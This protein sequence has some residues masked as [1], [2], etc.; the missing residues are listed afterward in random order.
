MTQ[1]NLLLYLMDTA[2]EQQLTNSEATRLFNVTQLSA[3]ASW[4]DYLLESKVDVAII[5]ADNL[6]HE[7][8]IALTSNKVMSKV[9]VIFISHGEPNDYIDEAMHHGVTYHLRLPV[10]IGFIN[11]LLTDFHQ[12]ILSSKNLS[13]EVT[14]SEL[15][16]FG[17]LVGSSQPMRT[18]Y[19][20][21]KKAADAEMN[22]FVVGESG[23]GKELV[24]RSVHLL[25]PLSQKPFV[26]I[27]CGAL[28]PELIESELFG[29]TKGAFTGAN[30]P[31]AGVFEQAEGGTLF[32]DE[33][34]EMPLDQ[35][36]KLLRVL[37]SGEYRPVGSEQIKKANVRI[38]SATNRD[39]QDAIK[40]ALFRED[41]FFRLAHFPLNV[42]P[43]R[44]RDD[45]IVGLAKH[46]LAYRNAQDKSNKEISSDALQKISQH[47]WPGNVRELKHAIER[48]YILANDVITADLIILDNDTQLRTERHETVPAGISL[49]EVERRAIL[50]TLDKNEGNKSATAD[51]LGVSIKTLYNKL[52]RYS[53]QD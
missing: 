21:I 11:E 33:V 36:V 45:D 48:A 25:S 51:D 38:I 47:S 26:A 6:T 34:T 50:K 53:K 19:R 35:Q 30:K 9:D 22:V 2:L 3:Q 32:L 44:E 5:Q 24:A 1:P 23:A 13:E 31:R 10:D 18:L 40:Q 4:T 37:E 29:H 12:D 7:Q 20:M 42:P 39:P 14:T 49:E 52:E 46:F 8:L 27:N 15:D 41:L 16:Q 43:L 17:L 28:S